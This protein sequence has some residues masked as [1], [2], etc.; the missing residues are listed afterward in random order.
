MNTQLSKTA[1]RKLSANIRATMRR[2]D[3]LGKADEFEVAYE[4]IIGAQEDLMAL[5]NEFYARMNGSM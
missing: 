1:Q 4:A 2:I 5:A 3:E